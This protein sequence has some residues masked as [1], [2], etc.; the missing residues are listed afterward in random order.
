MLKYDLQNIDAE[1]LK[2]SKDKKLNI[3]NTNPLMPSLSNA[4]D[5][6]DEDLINEDNI[7]RI[8]DLRSDIDTTQRLLADNR[9]CFEVS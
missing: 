1:T 4:D 3:A 6:F 7:E 5:Y 8:S 9:K 2:Y